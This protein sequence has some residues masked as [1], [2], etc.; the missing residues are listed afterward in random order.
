[1]LCNATLLL[2]GCA[3]QLPSDVLTAEGGVNT[4]GSRQ[5]FPEATFENI[6][7]TSLLDPEQKR[8]GYRRVVVAELAA[9]GTDLG[10]QIENPP[11]NQDLYG[12]FAAFYRYSGVDLKDTRNRVQDRMLAASEQRCNTYKN[13]LRRVDTSKAMTWPR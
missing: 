1:M 11:A 9:S 12:A 8:Q 3:S 5:F 13:Y 10:K 7:L 4:T 2:G 6:E